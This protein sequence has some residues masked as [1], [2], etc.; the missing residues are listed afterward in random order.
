M[1]QANRTHLWN[2]FPGLAYLDDQSDDAPASVAM[3]PSEV[4]IIFAGA[5]ILVLVVVAI[6]IQCCYKTRTRRHAM[7]NAPNRATGYADESEVSDATSDS[8]IT[9]SESDIVRAPD[10][11]IDSDSDEEESLL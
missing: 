3:F 5:L 2:T 11:A 8:Y 9:I 7:A 10:H 4:L 6:V 1:S